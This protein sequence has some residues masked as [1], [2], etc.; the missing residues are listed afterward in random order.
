MTSYASILGLGYNLSPY[1]LQV[2][3]FSNQHYAYVRDFISRDLSALDRGVE[4]GTGNYMRTSHY[5][6]IRA[7]ALQAH[8][9]I[10]MISQESFCPMNPKAFVD[11]KLRKGDLLLSKDSNIGECVL[12]D[13][14]YPHCMLGGALYKLPIREKKLYLFAFL[15]SHI[16]RDQLDLMVPKGA[17]IRHSGSKFLDC[18]IPLPVAHEAETVHLVER[19]VRS[20]FERERLIRRQTHSINSILQQELLSNNLSVPDA[21]ETVEYTKLIQETR[22]D[23][24]YHCRA[25]RQLVHAINEYPGGAL[26]L[27]ELEFGVKRGQNL[28]ISCIGKSLYSD[29]PIPGY[30][31]VI[32]PTNFSDYGTIQNYEYLGNPHALSKIFPGDLVFSAEGTIGKCVMFHNVSGACV[33]NIHGVVLSPQHRD[34]IQS[35]YVSCMLR[36]YR[37]CGLYD[38]ISVGGQGG[39][40]PLRYIES[41]KVPL[42]PHALIEKIGRLYHNP[43]PYLL[44][45]Y[46]TEF[47]RLDEGWMRN[48]GILELDS[49]ARVLRSLLSELVNDITAGRDVFA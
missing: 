40:L 6:F 21:W 11:Y 23:A 7:K 25:H 17:T 12:L 26:T 9:F 31:T 14:D 48:A 18:K 2:R 42:L 45:P 47:E 36:F 10:P 41:I 38:Y 30:Y 15:K 49:S 3:E 33:T 46:A 29:T 5:Y 39:S 27:R 16:F 44:D 8:S 28:Q 43:N 32:K 20:I 19:I 13:Q 4:I 35:A 37:H 34:S 1:Q 24:T 22:T